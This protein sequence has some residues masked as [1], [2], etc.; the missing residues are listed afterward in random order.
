MGVHGG[1]RE[2][3]AGSRSRGLFKAKAVNEVEDAGVGD[4]I[5]LSAVL[6][7]DEL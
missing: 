7:S 5:L 4:E 6:R 2:R 3:L 1:L